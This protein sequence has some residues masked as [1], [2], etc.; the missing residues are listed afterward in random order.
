MAL[1]EE[2]HIWVKP[3]AYHGT[4]SEN[5]ESIANHG[6][7][8]SGGV[9]GNAVYTKLDPSKVI[10]PKYNANSIVTIYHFPIKEKYSLDKKS[11]WILFPDDIS[12]RL[13]LFLAEISIE[14]ISGVYAEEKEKING[15]HKY[16]L[17][18]P[19]IKYKQSWKTSF[20]AVMGN[21]ASRI[22]DWYGWSHDK[23]K[24]PLRPTK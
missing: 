15:I 24:I 1:G 8:V 3:F 12:N 5:L 9:Y 18:V 19:S 6:L 16:V 17:H 22:I 2:K 4:K 21:L 10:I 20:N 7:F 23:Q 13:I 14:N 11:D